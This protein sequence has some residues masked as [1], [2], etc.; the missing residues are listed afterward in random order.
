MYSRA[1]G[2]RF[3]L[4][5]GLA[6]ACSGQDGRLDAA[7]AAAVREGVQA[8]LDAFLRYS[9]AGQWDSLVRL[10]A[11]GPGFRWV[12]QGEVR[13]RSIGQIREAL[14]VLAP[15]TR[16]ETTYRDTEI[17]PL[18]P[19]VALVVTHFDTRLG[20]FG[21]GGVAT[22]VLA[23]RAGRWLLVAGHSSSPEQQ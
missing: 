20:D 6:G 12:E 15:G 23:R 2:I 19:S 22:I 5:I 1:I 11:D 9:A 21:F 17:T 13:Y 3:M 16:I 4:V 14:G 7:D 8:T 10:Y 18:S